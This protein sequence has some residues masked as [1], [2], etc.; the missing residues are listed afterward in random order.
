MIAF[1][2]WWLTIQLFGLAALPLTARV[3]RWLPGQGYAFSKVFGLLLVSYLLWLGAIT[4]VLVNNLG[5]ILFALLLVAGLS[6]WA[7]F[8]AQR[9]A[10]CG[11]LKE[12]WRKQ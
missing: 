11:R 2:S 4:G 1:L 7:C 12:F 3:M 6:A 9:E 10:H 5:G 8:H